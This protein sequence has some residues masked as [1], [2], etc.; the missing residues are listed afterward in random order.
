[1]KQIVSFDGQML[2]FADGTKADADDYAKQNGLDMDS[3]EQYREGAQTPATPPAVGG[4]MQAVK[5]AALP[6][7]TVLLLVGAVV[8]IMRIRK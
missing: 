5:E 4:A 1:M 7:A 6:V 3:F 2:T 8:G